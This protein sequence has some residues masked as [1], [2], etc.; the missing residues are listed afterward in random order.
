MA[1]VNPPP[2]K[3]LNRKIGKKTLRKVFPMGS[4]AEGKMPLRTPY[5]RK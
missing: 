4:S 1:T 3:K 2:T 5:G